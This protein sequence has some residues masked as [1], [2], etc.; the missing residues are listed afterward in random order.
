MIRHYSKDIPGIEYNQA[1]LTVKYPNGSKITLY[2]SDNPDSLRGIALWGAIFDEYA[3]QPGNIFS[4]IILPALA[5]HSGYAI[6]IGTPKGKNVFFDLVQKARNDDDYLLVDIKAS[7]SGV[8]PESELEELKKNMTEDEYNQEFECSFESSVKGAIYGKELAE[9]RTAGRITSVPYERLLQVYTWWDL[10]MSDAT[11]ILFFQKHGNSWRLIDSYENSG[12]GLDF[13]VKI[14]KEKGYS[15]AKH[16]FPHDI[17]VKELGTG[18]SR[19]EILRRLG[20]VPE[21]VPALNVQEGINATRMKMSTLWIDEK[22][23]EKFLRAITQYQREWDE[24]RGMFK[25][26][27]LHDWTSH[28]ADALRYWGITKEYRPQSIQYGS[29]LIK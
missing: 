29:S 10:G 13:Y 20:V 24:K 11:S 25:E 7:T 14:L 21:V 5:D 19:L 12:E 16:Y 26:Q 4:E 9:M 2:G 23:N 8:L 27:P 18:V 1:E 6:W 22:N 15:Y 28:F 3:Q 17:Q